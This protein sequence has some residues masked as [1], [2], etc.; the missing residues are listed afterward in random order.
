MEDLNC[1]AQGI[2]Y[3]Q[4]R[5]TEMALQGIKDIFLSLPLEL[6]E[7]LGLRIYRKGGGNW[8]VEK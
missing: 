2:P 1:L 8:A 6:K 7:S 4:R 3:Q 5:V